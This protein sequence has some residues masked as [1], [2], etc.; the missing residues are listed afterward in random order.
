MLSIVYFNNVLSDLPANN[1]Q[2]FVI[3]GWNNNY[4]KGYISNLRIVGG[5]GHDSLVYTNNFTVPSSNLTAITN[6][7]LLCCQST[8]DVTAKAVGGNIT[9]NGDPAAGAQTVTSS[10]SVTPSEPTPS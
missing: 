7:K 5:G 4:F 2:P 3:G 1:S 9:S 8:S 10:S 6:T